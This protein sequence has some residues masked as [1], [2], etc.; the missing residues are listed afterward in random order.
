MK[1]KNLIY[2]FIIIWLILTV[3]ILL[4]NYYPNNDYMNIY[5]LLNIL[6]IIF[7]S[8]YFISTK[9][10]A[11]FFEE[12]IKTVN[13]DFMIFN[14]NGYILYSKLDICN[15]FEQK[16][17]NDKDIYNIFKNEK[18]N[19]K[20]S[21]FKIN[22]ENKFLKINFYEIED[23][24]LLCTLKDLTST[25]QLQE[26]HKQNEQ[27][28]IQQSKMAS[29][30]EMISSIAHQWR[31]PLAVFSGVLSN[32]E[33]AY[34]LK[35]L[36]EKYLKKLLDTG[37]KNINFMSKTID[38]FRNFFIPCKEKQVFSIKDSIVKSLYITNAQFQE[39]L[40]EVSINSKKFNVK[41][42]FESQD[43]F[44]ILG[45]ANEFAHVLVN[46]LVNSKDEFIIKKIKYPKIDINIYNENEYI[47][48]DIEDN[49]QGIK[50]ENLTKIF[51]PYF[52]TKKELNGTGIGLYMCKMIIE[53]SM[54]G[55][56]EAFNTKDGALF[57]IKLKRVDNG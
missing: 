52:S 37:N 44:N 57:R 33:D 4:L 18:L 9:K 19:E 10:Q 30:G 1:I 27:L 41:E 21:W 7:L 3:S 55:S 53:K 28:L 49:A 39:N 47:V 42:K 15:F 22:N 20:S 11:T 8:Y 25:M 2:L 17:F 48:V 38:D 40:I 50:K 35:I 54:H 5:F 26:S 32:I 24:N 45:Y 56:I 31:Q 23:N 13:E 14:K 36:D 34:E 12:I 6:F 43:K 29:M 51:D 46:L 16:D